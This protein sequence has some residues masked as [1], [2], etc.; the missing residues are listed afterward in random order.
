MKSLEEFSEEIVKYSM[1][2]FL[3]ESLKEFSEEFH[4][5][6]MNFR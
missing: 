1:E 5:L 3:E 6:W 4:K 2:E